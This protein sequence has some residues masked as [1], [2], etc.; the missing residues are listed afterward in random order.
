MMKKMTVTSLMLAISL[1]VAPTS[2]EGGS[3]VYDR[4]I[5]NPTGTGTDQ[6]GA[7]MAQS[8]ND[9]LVGSPG[10]AAPNANE[11]AAYLFDVTDGTLQRTFREPTPGWYYNFGVSVSISGTT[12]VIGKNPSGGSRAF[13]FN[14]TTGAVVTIPAP[15]NAGYFGAERSVAVLGAAAVVSAYR[16]DSQA[17]Q[18][19]RAYVYD[20]LGSLWDTIDNP[21]SPP[22]YDWFGS[23]IAA[24][25]TRILVGAPG[26]DPGAANAG[27]AFLF[28]AA[29]TL[30]RTFNNPY[31]GSNDRFGW[32]VALSDD[33]VLVGDRNN[34]SSGIG[35]AYLFDHGGTLLRTLANPNPSN[36]DSFSSAMAISGDDILIGAPQED[37]YGT[38]AGAAYL[39]DAV[40]GSLLQT[41]SSPTAAAGDSFG[42]S[43]GISGD[44]LAVGAPYAGSHLGEVHVFAR[45]SACADGLDNDG[46]G[47]ADY[48]ADPGCADAADDSERDETGTYPCDNGLDDD[49]DG[50]T[51]CP[52]DPG[53]VHPAAHVE[54]PVCQD[55]DDNDGDGMIDF[56][57]GLSALGHEAAEPDP[58]CHYAWLMEEDPQCGLG[59]ELA[60]LLPPL[61]WLSRRRF[62]R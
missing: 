26:D 51:D 36:G 1:L 6:F 21:T 39:F 58:H 32:S 18:S 48:P 62:L 41:L 45:S 16:D 23:A 47:P 10:E 30:L 24:T 4:T 44:Y 31:P 50:L 35:V 19:G 17:P 25:D 8:G 34:A 52:D 14:T 55:G 22:D 38:D 20:A 61:M 5:P 37:L 13:R 28:D 29:G 11:G 15:P 40:S 57:G 49:D 56:D 53:C 12:A 7:A 54:D 46:D 27:A 9:L 60:L 59:A 33:Y 3:F 42:R 43:V 2:A